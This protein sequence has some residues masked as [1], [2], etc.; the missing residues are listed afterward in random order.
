MTNKHLERF[1]FIRDIQ[2]KQNTTYR[3]KCILAIQI[4]QMSIRGWTD[5]HYAAIQRILVCFIQSVQV[6]E[7]RY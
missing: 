7:A 5:R 2:I 6:Q 3:C 4:T 1:N